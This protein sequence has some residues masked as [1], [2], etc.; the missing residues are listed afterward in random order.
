MLQAQAAGLWASLKLISQLIQLR[1][2]MLRLL[3]ATS[4]E[5][6]V[7]LEPVGSTVGALKRQLATQLPYSRF[8]LR[9][10][11]GAKELLD[12]EAIEEG[13]ALLCSRCLP[14]EAHRDEEFLQCCRQG[15]LEE[16]EA[17][18]K[19]LQEPV[20]GALSL[21][22]EEGHLQVL[23]LLQEARAE[24]ECSGHVALLILLAMSRV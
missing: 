21:A 12:E 17:R 20:V 18:L 10:L 4:G 5:E 19:A 6:L 11:S 22:A 13:M 2:M 3:S 7:A 8:Q 1:S 9:L 23:R 16:V 14:P 15:L 24:L